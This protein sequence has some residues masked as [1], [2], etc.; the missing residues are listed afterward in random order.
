M[1]VPVCEDG[2]AGA[3]YVLTR[4]QSLSQFEQISTIGGAIGRSL[5]IEEMSSEEARDELLT[6]IPAFAVK[7]LLDAWSAAIKKRL[8]RSHSARIGRPIRYGSSPAMPNTWIPP[9][10]QA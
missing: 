1:D 4:P 6:S 7:M 10:S 3:E 9:I 8:G 2:H 5:R